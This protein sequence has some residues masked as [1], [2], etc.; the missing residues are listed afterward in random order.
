MTPRVLIAG[1]KHETNTFSVLPTDIEAYRQRALHRGEDIARVYPGTNT[2]AAAFLDGCQ[3]HGWQPVLTVVGDATPSGKLTSDCYEAMAGEIL[4]GVDKLG[5]VEAILLNLHGAM[6]A[7]HVDDGEGELIARLRA[8]AG[9]KV[10]IAATLDLHANVTDRMARDAD[11]IVSYRTY[12]HV[13]MYEI[14]SEAV[15]LVARALKGEIRPQTI[16]RRG[17]QMKGLDDGKTTGPGPM[18][19]ALAMARGFLNEPGVLSVSINA[20]FFKADIAEVGPSVVVVADGEHPEHAALADEI[21][22]FMWDTRHVATVEHTTVAEA[23]ARAKASGRIGAPVVIADFADNPGGGGYSDSVGL[24]KGMLEAGLADAA[25]S[26]IV[27]PQSAAACAKA[28]VGA[29]LTLDIGGKTD[30][31]LATPLRLT[32]TVTHVSDGRFTIEGPMMRGMKIDMGTTAAFKV[33]GVEIVLAS[34]RFQNYDLGF[35]TVAGIDPA[36]RAVLAVKSMQHFR[37]AYAPIAGDIVVVDEGD[38][39]TSHDILKLS[40]EKVRRP[41]FPLDLD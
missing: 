23:V 40:F 11:I 15:D 6:V 39:I 30:P 34:R 31:R 17:P 7:E 10:I 4:A 9:P 8:K 33:G 16:V 13:D 12:P 18:N 21:V 35:F 37:A 20:G 38:G 2:E 14:A 32:G 25:I 22:A 28:G 1:F 27:D 5:G 36:R 26:S 24:L 41:I 29:T 3:R 19:D